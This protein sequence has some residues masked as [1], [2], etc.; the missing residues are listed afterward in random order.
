[1]H[2][3]GPGFWLQWLLRVIWS[4][5]SFDPTFLGVL[6]RTLKRQRTDLEQV[7]PAPLLSLCAHV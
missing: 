2:N 7:T 1:M 3:E 6:S 5:G 4:W